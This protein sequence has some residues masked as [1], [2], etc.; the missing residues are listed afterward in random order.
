MGHDMEFFVYSSHNPLG[1]NTSYE[2][3][4]FLHPLSFGGGT[5]LQI[6]QGKTMERYKWV[7]ME[8][9]SARVTYSDLA[10]IID[11]LLK[12]SSDFCVFHKKS[13]SHTNIENIR[14]TERMEHDRDIYRRDEEMIGC[15]YVY[16]LCS[17]LDL[18]VVDDTERHFARSQ[19]L[20]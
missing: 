3:N 7:N 16:L 4:L 18:L 12:V 14:A 2:K 20:V 9:I 8:K 17:G 1:S 19:E 5:N 6:R 10:L 11:V 13:I 15:D